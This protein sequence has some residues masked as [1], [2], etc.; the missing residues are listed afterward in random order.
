MILFWLKIQTKMYKSNMLGTILLVIVILMQ[1]GCSSSK[2]KN[3]S[4]QEL[5]ILDYE[6]LQTNTYDTRNV[7]YAELPKPIAKFS[8]D[9]TLLATV[10]ENGRALLWESSSGKL[11]QEISHIDDRVYDIA[12]TPDGTLIATSTPS[13]IFFWQ[14]DN[15]EQFKYISTSNGGGLAFSADGSLLA[16]NTGDVLELW[17]WETN[18]KLFEEETPYPQ[19]RPTLD[20]NVLF[21]PNGE[22]IAAYENNGFYDAHR[23]NI[24]SVQEGSVITTISDPNP[25]AVFSFLKEGDLFAQCDNGEII[26]RQVLSGDIINTHPTEYTWGSCTINAMQAFE[27]I[28]FEYMTD[29]GLVTTQRSD[30]K[31]GS[32]LNFWDVKTG[33]LLEQHE[34]ETPIIRPSFR[35]AITMSTDNTLLAV[36]GYAS[37]ESYEIL[38]MYV[39]VFHIPE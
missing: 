12:F 32:L 10:N 19:S 36:S 14:L 5:Y 16:T 18:V 9:N 26:H 30:N 29:D 15:G 25:N 4:V 35:Q 21:S 1:I 2:F 38:S 20:L 6:E 28:S 22:Y 23:I 33:E 3:D 24:W 7:S 34:I 31:V 37:T 13:G 17:Q 11:L 39:Q 27:L 8:L